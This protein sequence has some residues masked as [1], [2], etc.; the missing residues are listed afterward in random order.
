MGDDENENREEYNTSTRTDALSIATVNKD[1]N[2]VK[3]GS[4]PQDSLVYIP[5]VGYE[6]KIT[7]AHAFGGTKA[8]IESVENKLELPVD[9]YVKLN[10]H[11]FVDVV[12]AIK[13]GRASCRERV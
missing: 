6:D 11:A 10:F 13:I 4:I 3:L 12:N 8:T 9:Y 2:S 7:H 1:D 5:E